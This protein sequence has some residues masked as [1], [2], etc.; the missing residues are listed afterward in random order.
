LRLRTARRFLSHGPLLL[1][2]VVLS[3][4]CTDTGE[5]SFQGYV[6]GEFVY[7][8]SPLGGRLETLSVRRGQTVKVGDPLFQLEKDSEKA[9]VQEALERLRQ[10]QN[11]LADLQKGK[12]QGSRRPRRRSSSPK[13]P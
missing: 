1:L 9:A 2:G 8:A 6:E 3:G 5:N 7:V 10:A 11:R 13:R 12:R 4:G